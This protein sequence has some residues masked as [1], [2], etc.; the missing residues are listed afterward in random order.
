M[1]ANQGFTSVSNNLSAASLGTQ[2]PRNSKKLGDQFVQ[3]VNESQLYMT[4]YAEF[5]EPDPNVPPAIYF[6]AATGQPTG[7]LFL[8]S[9]VNTRTFSRGREP[10]HYTAPSETSKFLP[11]VVTPPGFPPLPAP[12]PVV[13][14]VQAVTGL[15]ATVVAS[16]TAVLLVAIGQFVGSGGDTRARVRG[17]GKL[18]VEKTVKFQVRVRTGFLFTPPSGVSVPSVGVLVG[19][20]DFALLHQLIGLPA[21]PNPTDL[22]IYDWTAPI[23]LSTE[24]RFVRTIATEPAPVADPFPA[25]DTQVS[26]IGS[27]I[28]HDGNYTIVGSAKPADVKFQAPPE[29]LQFLF[30]VPALTD[31]EFAVRESGILIP[32]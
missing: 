29:L 26:F 4:H 17:D 22:V 11:Y 25:G 15:P 12:Q 19:Y 6:D 30:Q 9:P 5:G 7:E 2:P 32:V 27:E 8:Q 14:F 10:H 20:L 18:E 24:N 3:L 23:V 16:N 21:P 13:G 28:D 31:V 1:G